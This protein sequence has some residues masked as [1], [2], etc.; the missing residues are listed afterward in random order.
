MS[1]APATNRAPEASLRFTPGN[2]ASASLA[3][4]STGHPWWASPSSVTRRARPRE[5]DA[6]DFDP[7]EEVRMEAQHPFERG[8]LDAVEDARR[9]GRVGKPRLQEEEAIA[10]AGRE[11]SAGGHDERGAGEVQL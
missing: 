11:W 5:R 8:A 7:P 4:T 10:R 6:L 2:D 9:H 1:S 3:S